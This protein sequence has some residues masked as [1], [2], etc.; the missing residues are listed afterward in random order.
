MFEIV[1][2]IL[3]GVCAVVGIVLA[4]IQKFGG[5]I[6][7]NLKLRWRIIGCIV[8]VIAVALLHVL[9]ML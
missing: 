6:G 2:G 9:D 1:I 3:L 7:I 5:F 8:A 4:S